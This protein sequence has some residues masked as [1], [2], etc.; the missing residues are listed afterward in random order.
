MSTLIIFLFEAE[1]SFWLENI[2][3]RLELNAYLFLKYF[4]EFF[5]TRPFWVRGPL[6]AFR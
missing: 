3:K 1:Q 4:R 2:F 6:A 5:R